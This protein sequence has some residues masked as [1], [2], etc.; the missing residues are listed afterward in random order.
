MK[1]NIRTIIILHIMLFFYSFGGVCS[2][3]AAGEEFLSRRFLL[4]YGI[5]LF[6]LAVYAFAWQQIIKRMPLTLAYA[7]KAVSLLWAMVWGILLFREKI[8]PGKIIGAI[9]VATGIVLFAFSDSRDVLKKENLE[10][11]ECQQ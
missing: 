6:L 11:E 1:S 10:A 8:T 5:V 2:K 4:Y 3:Y 7:N 9:L